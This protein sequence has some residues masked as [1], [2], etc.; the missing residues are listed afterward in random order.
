MPR[1]SPA[2]WRCTRRRSP[3]AA[4]RRRLEARFRSCRATARN[5][6]RTRE[7]NGYPYHEIS[8]VVGD[9]VRELVRMLARFVRENITEAARPSRRQ[10]SHEHRHLRRHVRSLSSRPPRPDPR[11][12]RPRC[13]GIAFSMSPRSFSRSSRTAPPRRPYHRFAMARR[14]HARLRRSACLADGA[15]ARRASRTP[16]TRWRIFARAHPDAT[17]DWIIG[18]DNLP[19]ARGV[20]IDRHDLRAGE[21]RR[22]D[23]RRSTKCRRRS[24]RACRKPRSRPAQHGAIVFAQNATVPVSSTEIRRRLQA[25]QSDRR[26]GSAAR[27]AL[28]STL[29]TLSK[30]PIVNDSIEARVRVAVAAALD[31]KAF[32]LDVLAVGELTSIA[33]YFILAPPATSARRRPSPTTSLDQLKQEMGVKPLLVEGDDAGTLGPAGLRRLHRPYLHRG[34]AALLRTGAALGRC[35]ECDGRVHR[36]SR[37]RVPSRRL[38]EP[39]L[40]DLF[41]TRN[42][43]MRNILETVEKVLDHDVSILI[44]G[45]SGVGKDYLA[46]VHPRLQRAPRR[47]RSSTSNAPPF[48]LISSKVSYSATSAARSPT[49]RC[50]R[51]ASWKRRAAAPST[52]T[53][54]SA[55]TPQLQAKLL[56][57]MQERRFSR[58]GGAN[59]LPFEAR[60]ISSSNADAAALLASGALRSDLYYRINVVTLTLPPLRERPEDVLSL[61]RQFVRRTQV[62]P[63]RRRRRAGDARATPGPA[64]CASCAT[65]SSAPA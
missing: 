2:S 6:A 48:L 4:H 35:A 65:P 40:E 36:R 24:R 30:G 8:A 43:A 64:T 19:Q 9:G 58:L 62:P 53:R 50:A 56:R 61:A 12:A 52:S 16:S 41:R 22:A 27:L 57:V 1:S 33:D 31:K 63:I 32:D 18:D 10:R 20:E 47:S 25:G 59:T 11:R 26:S 51:S 15:R 17:L 29:R 45:E 39:R 28:H 7:K 23:A 54:V 5:C 3:E 13:S 55:L 46:R 37:A 38:R 34:R 42:A 49:R 21:L 14:G 60:V 44:L